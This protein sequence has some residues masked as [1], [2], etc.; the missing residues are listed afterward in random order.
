M[1][2]IIPL[3]LILISA[4]TIIVIISRHYSEFST[5]EVKKEKKSIARKEFEE[6]VVA[7]RLEKNVIGFFSKKIKNTLLFLKNIGKFG[8][9]VHDSLNELKQ[10][11]KNLSSFASKDIDEQDGFYAKIKKN[12]E[13]KVHYEVR[14]STLDDNNKDMINHEERDGS[15]SQ[16]QQKI[17]NLFD[18]V[19]NL[20]KDK[21][22]GQ[23]EKKLIEII[24]LDHKNIDAF[25]A[26]GEIYFE[27]NKY[28]EAVQTM[29]H[30][31]KLGGDADDYFN[32]A[33]FCKEINDFEKAISN[34]KK[35]I[36]MSPKNTSFLDLLFELSVS[37]K[38]K[39]SAFEA[40][41]K[42]KKINPSNS[43]LDK[44]KLKIQD[45]NK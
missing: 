1:Y 28:D 36:D 13:K 18:E 11:N 34:I 9:K 26:L 35:A 29:E 31:I 12:K 33:L 38:N 27:Q 16:T 15:N 42:L 19:D 44:L 8:T 24:K 45:I 23:A 32:L 7:D 25:R 10:D 30:V 37:A 4:I 2:N 41:Y 5:L 22:F 21:D 40:Y 17:N 20:V 43:K 39:K 14:D 6:Q 3:I